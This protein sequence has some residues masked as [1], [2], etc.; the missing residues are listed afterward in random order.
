MPE[1]VAMPHEHSLLQMIAG[2]SPVVQGVLFVLIIL[3]ILSWAIAIAKVL[4]F[5]KAHAES[6]QFT[7]LFWESRNFSRVDDSIRRLSASPLAR[8]FSVGYR[9]VGKTAAEKQQGRAASVSNSIERVLRRAEQEE[10]AKLERGLTFLATVASAAPFIG[11]FGT[12]WGIMNAFQGLG[13]P[14]AASTLQAVA[15]GISEALVA[16]AIGLAAAIPAAVAYNYFVVGLR[17]FR[18]SMGCFIADFLALSEGA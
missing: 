6:E 17:H 3:S 5:R 9:E 12:V 18:D 8:L 10:A 13:A 2:S 4:Q 14:G 7:S 11:L 1:N 16:T 15:P